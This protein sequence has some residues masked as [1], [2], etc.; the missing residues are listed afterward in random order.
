MTAQ[1]LS[2]LAGAVLSLL[3]SYVPGFSDYFDKIDPVRRRLV[4]AALLVLA[5]ALALIWKCNTFSAACLATNWQDYV[6]ALGT[7]L[8][9]N[10]SVFQISPQPTPAAPKPPAPPAA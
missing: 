9:V 8:V 1:F 5:A 7:A 2:G 4:M 10:Q 6:T 3:F